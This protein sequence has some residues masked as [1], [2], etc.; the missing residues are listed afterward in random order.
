MKDRLS[1]SQ[2]AITWVRERTVCFRG[3]LCKSEPYATPSDDRLLGDEGVQTGV[4]NKTNDL[5]TFN[6]ATSRIEAKMQFSCMHFAPCSNHYQHHYL[7]SSPIS[8]KRAAKN[9]NL[10]RPRCKVLGST[11]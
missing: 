1:N 11:K 4:R 3:L 2:V 7:Y 6:K 10:V 9:S 8:P 5:M